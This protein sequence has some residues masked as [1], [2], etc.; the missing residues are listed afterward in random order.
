MPGSQALLWDQSGFGLFLPD[1]GWEIC[2]QCGYTKNIL[3]TLGCLLLGEGGG[4]HRNMIILKKWREKGWDKNQI[5]VASLACWLALHWMNLGML[6]LA[7]TICPESKHHCTPYP[8]HTIWYYNIA[9]KFTRGIYSFCFH[10]DVGGC[11]LLQTSLSQSA[12]IAEFSKTVL[13]RLLASGQLYKANIDT[14]VCL[15]DETTLSNNCCNKT[16]AWGGG[17]SICST[18]LILMHI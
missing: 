18:M 14:E 10:T 2:L 12:V 7:W 9:L 6:S 4:V 1:T 15:I 17:N 13:H 5:I 3:S 16:K 8:E 11:T